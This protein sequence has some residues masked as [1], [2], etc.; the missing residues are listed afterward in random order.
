MTAPSQ[1]S[2]TT[3]KLELFGGRVWLAIAFLFLIGVGMNARLNALLDK[4]FRQVLVKPGPTQAWQVGAEATVLVT[5]ITADAERL[6]CAHATSVEGFHCAY[7]GNRRPW[8]AEPGA[9]LDD[10]GARTIQPYRTADSNA[11][12]FIAGLWNQPELALRRHQE[13][14]EQYPVPKLLR[15]TAYCKVTFIAPLQDVAVR[16]DVKGAWDRNQSA[17]LARPLGCSLSAPAP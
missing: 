11:L 4:H 17:L 13:P 14:P 10:N 12:I 9:P 15:F 16:W 2:G 3:P 6:A 7:D 5:L 1:S 8:P